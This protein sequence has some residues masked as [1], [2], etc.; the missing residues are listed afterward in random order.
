LELAVRA[1]GWQLAAARLAAALPF[2]VSIPTGLQSSSLSHDPEVVRAYDADPYVRGKIT[3]RLLVDV[4][5]AGQWALA[6]A[7]ELGVPVLL[8]HGDADEI[9]SHGASQRFARA[10]GP[11]V[12]FR[13]WPGGFHE[14]HNE[15]ERAEVLAVI[16]DW[17]ASKV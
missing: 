3:P 11:Q 15:P 5:D 1:P 13:S 9:T 8:L 14:L 10:A 12:T 6:R 17:L 4:I 2:A 7:G 16:T